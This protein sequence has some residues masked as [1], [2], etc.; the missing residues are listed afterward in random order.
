MSGR[1]GI[2]GSV[3]ILRNYY[4]H[5]CSGLT[6]LLDAH[7]DGESGP[8]P[9]VTGVPDNVPLCEALSADD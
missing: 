5:H 8:G 2:G 7:D 3:N 1:T 4:L 9:G 6:G